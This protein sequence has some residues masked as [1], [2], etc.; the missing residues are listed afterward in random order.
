MVERTGCGLIVEKPQR[1]V[2]M[3]ECYR[4]FRC[5]KQ[6]GDAL[7]ISFLIS[8]EPQLLFSLSRWRERVGVR[9]VPVR[10][11]GKFRGKPMHHPH[12]RLRRGLSRQRER[13]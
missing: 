11:S 6:G 13:Q 9:V 2:L 12:P 1:L 3:R 8:P 7:S 4:V 10:V 5:F